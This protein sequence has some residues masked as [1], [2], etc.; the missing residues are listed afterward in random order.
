MRD[1]F[2]GR[3]GRIREDAL[4]SGEVFRAGQADD[5]GTFRVEFHDAGAMEIAHEVELRDAVVA[6]HGA[7]HDGEI[8]SFDVPFSV[9][10]AAEVEIGIEDFHAAGAAAEERIE[11]AGSEVGMTMEVELV[12][13]APGD[14]AGVEQGFE[15]IIVKA[16]GDSP[17]EG[18][19]PS[20]EAMGLTIA[21]EFVQDGMGVEGDVAAAAGSGWIVGG[22]GSAMVGAGDD[23]EAIDL[24]TL[25]RGGGGGADDGDCA[26]L[27][28][29]EEVAFRGGR[30]RWGKGKEVG[31]LPLMEREVGGEAISCGLADFFDGGEAVEKVACQIKLGLIDGGR[32]AGDEGVLGWRERFGV[33]KRAIDRLFPEGTAQSE[34]ATGHHLAEAEKPIGDGEEGGGEF[35]E[36]VEKL[37]LGG[38]LGGGIRA[39]RSAEAGEG[40]A[41]LEG[42]TVKKAGGFGSLEQ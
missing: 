29:V 42:E 39:G 16:L 6:G 37:E 7:E 40:A 15:K 33:A 22:L 8:Q 1:S 30:R 23:V 31:H 18:V 28:V 41:G 24:G 12:P 4:E 34:G 9:R 20:S 27:D 14:F 35:A 3:N 21:L 5:G 10:C 11:I 36:M 38:L 25:R 32:E 2:R 17:V 26:V 13:L 19:Q